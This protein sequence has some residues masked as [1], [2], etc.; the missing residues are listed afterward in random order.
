MSELAVRGLDQVLRRRTAGPARARPHRAAAAR[1][2]PCSGP[3]GCGKTTLLRIVAGFLR[4]DAGTV[5]VGGRTLTG[6]GVASAAGAAPHRHRPAGGR[7]VPAPERGAQRRLRAD[8]PSTARARRA[9][10]GGDAGAGRARPAT[11]T[12]CRTSCPAASSSAS[13]WPARSRRDPRWCCSTSRSTPS[14]A[15]CAPAVRADVRAAL[16][17]TGATAVLVTH[18]Q[19]E[20]LSTADLVAVVR[21]G[22][23]RPVRH[24]PQ[25]LYRA[26][27]RPLGRRLRRRRRPAPRHRRSDGTAADRTGPRVPCARRRTA[28]RHGRCSGRSSSMTD[29]DADGRPRAR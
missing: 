9:P 21:D 4:A 5:A 10:H 29:T 27:R 22:P 7:A 18:D 25:E 14:T 19:Q 6:P 23:D 26:P 20:A 11:A 17:A 15:R 28:R 3:S 16:R 1:W 12:G 2:P 13:P 24:A 8:R